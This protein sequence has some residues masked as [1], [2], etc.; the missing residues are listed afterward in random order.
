MDRNE[1]EDAM[2]RVEDGGLRF[3]GQWQGALVVEVYDSAGQPKLPPPH[4]VP[5][6]I[7][8]KSAASTVN[9]WLKECEKHPECIS[10]NFFG[11]R[12]LQAE[13]PGKGESET[14]RDLFAPILPKRMI[15]L[16]EKAS[17]A[18]LVD[19]PSNT[20]VPYATL[21]YCWGED[22]TFMTVKDTLEDFKENIPMGDLPQTIKDAFCLTKGLGLDYLWVDAICIVQKEKEE[23]EE[24]SQKMG[25]IYSNA[26]IVLAATRSGNVHDG[27][28]TK[29]SA[30]PLSRD[31]EAPGGL[32]RARRNLNHEIIISCRT[33][34]DYWWEKYIKTSFPLLS[35]GWGFQE[36]MLSTR[37]VHFT[38][39]ELVWECQR[40]RRCECGVMESNLYPVM[41]NLGSALRMCLKQTNDDRSMRQMWREMVNSYSVRKL[42]RI[43]DKLPAL[44]G[45]AGL[46]KNRSGDTYCAGLWK[47]S[48][49]F[50]LLWRCDQSGDLQ[51]KKTRVPSW[52]WI[53]VDG[54]VKW[55]VCQN[56]DE[57][58][59][60]KYIRSTTYFECGA[61][62]IEVLD[63][64]CE[65]DGED[66][67][68]RVRAGRMKVE[69]RLRLV[70]I[71]RVLDNEWSGK[72]GTEWKV[73]TD[74]PAPAPFWP[75]V[76][77]EGLQVYPCGCQVGGP[78][79]FHIMEVMKSRNTVGSWEEAL[80]V[81]LVDGSKNYYERVGVAA[82]VSS[83]VRPW[84][85]ES[86]WFDSPLTTKITL[87]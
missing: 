19:T 42:T 56:P 9:Q 48:L 36:R 45:I 22:A 35:R 61:Q 14:E 78:H 10:H 27:M 70:T 53:S 39:T 79:H 83:N 28:F 72:F 16:G 34:S 11:G 37:I 75:D 51:S 26:K 86:S 80:V 52:S 50:D 20:R 87:V 77:D 44:S 68:G 67:Y 43:N 46:F 4:D 32:M 71:S 33:K 47:K 31:I 30:T 84:T 74:I 6:D 3:T 23:W 24:E 7:S 73:H 66:A 63:V 21:S 29:R 82:N 17:T 65:L 15:L 41:N 64:K 8:C 54:A 40:R 59:P 81:R 49:P 57:E 58:Q 38:P 62:G 60:L 2:V 55:P 18:R 76:N 85:T 12:V 25:H 1:Y 5:A 13:S 69:T